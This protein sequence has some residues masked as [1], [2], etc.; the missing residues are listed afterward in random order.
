MIGLQKTEF[1]VAVKMDYKY[2][3]Q[4]AQILQT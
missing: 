1:Y 4:Y 3:H 2:V